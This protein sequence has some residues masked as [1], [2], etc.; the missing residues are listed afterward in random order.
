VLGISSGSTVGVMAWKLI[1]VLWPAIFAAWPVWLLALG[2]A[3]PAMVGALVTCVV[4]FLLARGK[5]GGGMQPV[6]LLLVGVV[7]SSINGALLLVLN[8]LAPAGLRSNLAVYIM[9][10]ISE[11][12]L[13]PVMLVTATAV[14]LAGYLPVLLSASALNIGTLSDTEAT[15]LGVNLQRLRTLCFFCASIMTGAAILL[16]GPIGFVGLICPHICRRLRWG[17]LGGGADHR[18]LLVAAPLCG[19]VFLIAADTLVRLASTFNRGEFP[20]GVVTALCGGPF[21]LL[22]LWRQMK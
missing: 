2:R 12:D 17:G 7:V 13:T 16:S 9:G 20:V 15:S 5:R 19:A 18:T 6:T 1:W 11:N 14:M 3:L 22:L 10:V 4:V 8:S 21:F